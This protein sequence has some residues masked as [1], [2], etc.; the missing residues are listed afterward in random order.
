VLQVLAL[1][2]NEWAQYRVQSGLASGEGLI[3]HVR[4]PA[5]KMKDSQQ[6]E[7]DPGVVDKR[8]LIDAQEFASVLAV[9]AKPGSTLSA[10]IRNAWSH[11]ALQT[12]GKTWPDRSTGSARHVFGESTGNREVD[13]IMAALTCGE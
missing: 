12:L 8:L 4:D 3:H 9:M 6:E 2:D 1:A 7:V 11:K 5:F 13:I 10:V